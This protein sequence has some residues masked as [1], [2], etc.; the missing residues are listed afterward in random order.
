[1]YDEPNEVGTTKVWRHHYALATTA[2]AL[3]GVGKYLLNEHWQSTCHDKVID[4]TRLQ[5][6]PRRQGEGGVLRE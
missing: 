2:Q 1:M 5:N 6:F 3:G 4:G